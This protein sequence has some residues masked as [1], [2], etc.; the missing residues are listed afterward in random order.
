MASA[1]SMRIS[2]EPS[3][4]AHPENREFAIRQIAI[5]REGGNASSYRRLYLETGANTEMI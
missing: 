2:A 1:I 3:S 5:V 4:L